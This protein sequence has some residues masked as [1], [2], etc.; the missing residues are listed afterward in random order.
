MKHW[1]RLSC[2][3]PAAVVAGLLAVQ[4]AA[5]EVVLSLTG[6]VTDVGSFG[7]TPPSGVEAGSPVTGRVSYNPAEATMIEVGPGERAYV[8]LPGTGNEITIVIGTYEW[9]TDLQSIDLC[10]D[11]CDGDYVDIVGFSATTDNFPSNIGAGTL[12]LG[13]S[14]F[15]APY[16]L[17]HGADLPNGAEDVTVGAADS[18]NGSVSSS[19]GAS[20]FW[21]I[22]FDV[23]SATVPAT[24]VTW[25]EVKQLY[26]RP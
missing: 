2:L 5:A 23:D 17:I 19:D 25:S 6:T 8:F 26:A 15:Q 9:K 16:D 11:A 7:S 1:Y 22:A 13:F 3:A 14:D 20:G 21:A 18:A 10:D 12:S 24:R 4:P